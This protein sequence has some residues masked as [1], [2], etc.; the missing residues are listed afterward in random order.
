MVFS[1]LFG[2]FF[3]AQ[4]F[5]TTTTVHKPGAQ[6]GSS[7]VKRFSVHTHSACETICDALDSCSGTQMLS[8]SRR[9]PYSW[10]KKIPTPNQIGT[11]HGALRD[12]RS[13]LLKNPLPSIGTSHRGLRT[14]LTKNTPNPQPQELEFL[15]EDF[16][17][18]VLSLPKC[19]NLQ[20]CYFS[21]RT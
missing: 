18:L 8:K 3:F 19:P 14:E 4:R 12:F 7:E 5:L 16:G 2:L 10:I 1:I 17:T 21:W 15:M 13:E 11:S 20:N 6:Q 9:I